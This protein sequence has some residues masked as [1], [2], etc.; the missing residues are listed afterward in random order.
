[1]DL[2]Q[3]KEIT[4][5]CVETS[6]SLMM[7][8]KY[9]PLPDVELADLIEANRIIKDMEPEDDGE[10]R[11]RTYIHVDPRGIALHYAFK[12]FGLSP[13]EMLDALGFSFDED[14][15]EFCAGCWKFTRSDYVKRVDG[16]LYCDSCQEILKE[17]E[18]ESIAV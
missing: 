4:A 14:V 16:R 3:A 1:M 9:K 2:N 18:A 7:D 10:G 15:I 5:K 6:L 8:G 12:H 13:V 17:R 11:K